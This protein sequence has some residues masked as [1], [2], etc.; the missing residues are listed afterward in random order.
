MKCICLLLGSVLLSVS[1]T[2][3]VSGRADRVALNPP[4]VPAVI[5]A[6]PDVAQAFTP[7]WTLT[8]SGE[9]F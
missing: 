2:G 3:C 6:S 9:R 7:G 1:L 4:A 5:G 8:P